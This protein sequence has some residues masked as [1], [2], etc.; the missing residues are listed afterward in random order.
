MRASWFQL[1]AVGGA[2]E[3]FNSLHVCS[4][5]VLFPLF[6]LFGAMVG[7]GGFTGCLMPGPRRGWWGSSGERR[8]CAVADVSGVGERVLSLGPIVF[9]GPT[10]AGRGSVSGASDS[11][12]VNRPPGG[13][14][15]L[16]RGVRIPLLLGGKA[17]CSW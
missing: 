15:G 1:D 3:G 17:A 4:R 8:R 11:G 13:P 7:G 2:V 12:R 10:K 14:H 16:K 5:S 6:R 9:G